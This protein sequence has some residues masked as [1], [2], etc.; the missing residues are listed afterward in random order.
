M[1]EASFPITKTI[2]PFF[3][4]HALFTLTGTFGLQKIQPG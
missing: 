4:R 3:I 2:A 1:F